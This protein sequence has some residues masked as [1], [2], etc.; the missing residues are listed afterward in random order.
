MRATASRSSAIFSCIFL[1]LQPAAAST[2][3]EFCS[4]LARPRD[5]LL[6]LQESLS[7]QTNPI[8]TREIESQF[9]QTAVRAEN[10]FRSRYPGDITVDGVIGTVTELRDLYTSI[11]LT[12]EICQGVLL[13]IIFTD[14]GLNTWHSNIQD[15]ATVL[16][17]VIPGDKVQLSGL[18][19]KPEVAV[20]H[21]VAPGTTGPGSRDINLTF[22]LQK[23][24]KFN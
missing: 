13:Q 4:D 6:Q 3:T 2:Q 12:I 11:S 10:E 22:K 18:M 16:R 1:G 23:I 24:K 8:R 14:P 19:K 17:E 7:K 5:E 9:Q 21:Q 20:R 15:A